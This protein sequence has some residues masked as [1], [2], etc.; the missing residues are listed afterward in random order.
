MVNF[1]KIKVLSTSI[2]HMLLHTVFRHSGMAEKHGYE[3]EIDDFKA[4][5]VGEPTLSLSISLPKTSIRK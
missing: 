5:Q 4:P 3:L 1:K 2:S